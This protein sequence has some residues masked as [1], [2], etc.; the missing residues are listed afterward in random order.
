VSS[1]SDALRAAI[2]ALDIDAVESEVDDLRNAL[3]SARSQMKDAVTAIR[4]AL[5][6]VQAVAANIRQLCEPDENDLI[7]EE[8]IVAAVDSVGGPDS[9]DYGVLEDLDNAA[10][11][12]DS[13]A[14][15]VT[16]TLGDAEQQSQEGGA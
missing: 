4:E 16:S 11:S 6:T 1:A 3:D 14:D 8:H 7:H 13:A 2:E 9:S 10:D 12:L 15:E 5:G